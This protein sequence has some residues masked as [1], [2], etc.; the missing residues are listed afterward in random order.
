MRLS[1]FCDELACPLK[2]SEVMAT[3]LCLVL[4]FAVTALLVIFIGATRG[5]MISTSAFLACHQSLSAGS[6]LGWGLNF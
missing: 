5:V 3:E 2:Y 4:S 1:G 6:S